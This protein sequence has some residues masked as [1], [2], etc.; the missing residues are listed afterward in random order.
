MKN[1]ISAKSIHKSFGSGE[2]ATT[3]LRGVSLDLPQGQYLAV[4][5][6][7]GSGKTTL[8]FALSGTDHVDK[9]EVWFEGVRLCD[10]QENQLCDLR[11]ERMGFVF[12]QPTM[13]K[14]LN[15]LD[16]IL[17][18]HYRA[19]RAQRQALHEKAQ[20]LMAMTGLSGMEDRG[21]AQVSGGQLQ[22][23]GICRALVNQPA[24]VFADEPTGALNSQ[25]AGE[26]LS[27]FQRIHQD[28]SA[29]MV[30]T[31]DPRVAARA[32]RVLYMKDGAVEKDEY[33]GTWSE[34]LDEQ[35]VSHV[36]RGMRA[37]GI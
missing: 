5:G 15:L 11:R 2:E 27:L 24:I 36:A 6:P 16:N 1:L 9:G 18:P 35:R 30:V 31:H 10:L 34:A 19:P 21:T 13:I 4:V 25:A 17:L 22:R 33:L 32:Q 8:L 7:S 26:V 12:Q 28:G 3:V 23:A 20:A 37:L 29:L 14:E